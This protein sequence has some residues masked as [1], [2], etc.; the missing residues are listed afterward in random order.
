M[1]SDNVGLIGASELRRVLDSRFP[2]GLSKNATKPDPQHVLNKFVY[3]LLGG[4][5]ASTSIPRYLADA[6]PKDFA[7]RPFLDPN[8]EWSAGAARW[9]VD[10]LQTIY[11]PD[12]AVFPKMGAP[13]PVTAGLATSDPNDEGLGTGLARLMFA[14][15]NDVGQTLSEF[16]S[17]GVEQQDF[18]TRL[19]KLIGPDPVD[20]SPSPTK[21]ELPFTSW[22]PELNTYSNSVATF[23]ASVMRSQQHAQ[24]LLAVQDL[25][26][27]AYFVVT[28]MAFVP[29]IILSRIQTDGTHKPRLFVFGGSPPGEA[30]DRLIEASAL[31][32]GHALSQAYAG[33]P[34]M[35]SRAM[36]DVA[37]PSNQKRSERAAFVLNQ[38]LIDSGER[39]A[40]AK[41]HIDSI[42]AR[43]Q[44]HGIQLRDFAQKPE[45]VTEAIVH[46]SLS[47]VRYSSAIRSMARKVGFA[48]PDRGRKPRLV[49][50]TPLLATLVRGLVPKEGC[51]YSDFVDSLRTQ[52]GVVVGFGS[53]EADALIT[54]VGHW[55]SHAMAEELL[56][57]NE[58]RLRVRLVRAGLAQQYSDG[59]TEVTSTHG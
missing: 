40:T 31:Y 12:G 57:D 13:M 54:E 41:K 47:R 20:G 11:D 53:M 17:V 51:V 52:L 34:L 43:L 35:L 8:V 46:S 50:E 28:L 7:T 44:T 25:S 2:F 39:P 32:F 38:L 22:H 6:D 15:H 29:N 59:H 10:D 36:Q 19:S 27:A 21:G 55:A 56:R 9:L 26:R 49:L 58:E 16:L 42:A 1:A 33:I 4:G 24:R 48:A 14:T 23:L 45:A 30:G 3:R 5:P 37:I 18:V